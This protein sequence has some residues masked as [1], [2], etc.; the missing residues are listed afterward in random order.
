MKQL[1][2][3]FIWLHFIRNIIGYVILIG[4]IMIPLYSI[5]WSGIEQLD[6]QI[7]ALIMFGVILPLMFIVFL[8][9]MYAWSYLVWH[10]Y[11]YSLSQDTFNKEYG[12]IMKQYVSIPYARIQNVDIQRTLLDRLFG[13]ST[14][15]I[16]TAG[17]SGIVG[18]EGLL[19]GIS[20]D[21]A[22]VLREDLLKKVHAH[23]VSKTNNSGI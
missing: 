14:I 13:L 10:F 4:F 18:S 9:M 12:V 3:R 5:L 1:D 7:S 6:I 23:E 20:K 21:D 22:F 16:Q 17:A 11:R 2:K 8:G 15:R 19:P